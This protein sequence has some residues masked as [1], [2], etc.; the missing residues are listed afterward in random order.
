MKTFRITSILVLVFLTTLSFG[1]SSQVIAKVDHKTSEKNLEFKKADK[2][3]SVTSLE[4][5]KMAVAQIQKRLVENLV[6]PERMLENG[7]EGQVVLKVII[8]SKGKI[9][10]TSIAKSVNAYFD[11]ATLAAT[12]NISGID[13]KGQ[14]YQGVSTIYVPLNFSIGQ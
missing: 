8:T 12:K 5:S 9:S 14:K 13:L 2:P 7:I 4:H 10:H 11:Q 1:Q 6:Y 3:S